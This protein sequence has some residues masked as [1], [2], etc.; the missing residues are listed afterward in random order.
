[1]GGV[2]GGEAMVLTIID[3]VGNGSYV[4]LLWP[5]LCSCS[6]SVTPRCPGHGSLLDVL[7]G[8]T[9]G[10][11]SSSPPTVYNNQRRT[12]TCQSDNSETLG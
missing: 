8:D 9:G 5:V 10:V 12:H 11:P 6:D 4:G 2:D 3:P 1:M 7:S